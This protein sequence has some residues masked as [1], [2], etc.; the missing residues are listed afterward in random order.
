MVFRP[1]LC[2]LCVA[3]LSLLAFPLAALAGQLS[4]LA[5]KPDWSVLDAYQRTITRAEFTRLI[6]TIYTS[7]GAFWDYTKIDDDKVI[8]YS[9]L[10][11]TE[12]LFTLHFASSEATEAPLPYNYKTKAV[13]TDPNKPLKGIKIALDPGHIG[14]DWAKLPSRGDSIGRCG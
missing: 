13:S 2:L 14:G 11:K 4:P 10:A 8:V 3:A 5:P 9:D 7:D 12:P 6:D 1:L